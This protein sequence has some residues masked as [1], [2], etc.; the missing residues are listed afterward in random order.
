MNTK[1]IPKRGQNEA[2]TPKSQNVKSRDH[3]D[4]SKVED[5]MESR[6]Y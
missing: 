6:G 1:I 2:L 4:M 3:R 5:H